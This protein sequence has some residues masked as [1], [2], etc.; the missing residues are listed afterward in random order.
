MEW[1]WT[2]V[3]VDWYLVTVCRYCCVVHILILSCFK[4]ISTCCL[5]KNTPPPSTPPSPSPNDTEQTKKSVPR[6]EVA[7]R[8]SYRVV[9]VD[10]ERL[11]KAASGL[12]VM[13]LLQ[14]YH[15]QLKA[16]PQTRLSQGL[17]DIYLPL[18]L[19]CTQ[20]FVLLI[21]HSYS[22]STN[23]QCINSPTNELNVLQHK[24]LVS[25]E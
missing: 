14:M 1:C 5:Q 18:T 7:V 4:Y 10:L 19:K 21:F 15:P 16:K 8:T 23:R 6:N 24:T 17:Q 12:C 20:E 11:L 9:R 25:T 13:L 22:A 2:T 3:S